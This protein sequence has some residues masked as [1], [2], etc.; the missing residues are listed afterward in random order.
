MKKILL[1]LFTVSSFCASA[2]PKSYDYAYM[3]KKGICVYSVAAK[4][5]YLADAKGQ[6]PCISP[7]GKKLAFTS[8]NK[9]GDRFIAVTDLATKKKTIFNTHNNNC[10]GPVW[11][12]NGKYIAYNAFDAQKS[13]WS[14]AIIDSGN[15]AVK[16]L[17]A[18]L[19][20]SY[21][22]SWTSDS[23]NVVVQNMEKV[24]V[25]DIAGNV[26]KTYNLGNIPMDFGAAS[27]DRFIFTDDYKKI[28]F[29]SEVN[30]D[31][32]DE[33]PPIAVFIY[34]I[35]Q[36]STMRLSPKG[37]FAEQIIIKQ[38]KVLFT[39]SKIHSTISNV[40]SVDMDGK[41]LKILFT[42]CSNVSAKN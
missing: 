13:K 3:N 18:S 42:H 32:G 24:F 17:T 35:A 8:S 36:K 27:S 33:G 28:V 6:D 26:I 12:P 30:E 22:P 11:S 16:I 9:A 4:M 19:E 21:S 37:Y 38:D 20:Q 10:Y 25:L 31:A 15:R 14:I 1:L 29:T 7:D 39:L 2:Q 5:E 41:N 23:K 40:C 34:D